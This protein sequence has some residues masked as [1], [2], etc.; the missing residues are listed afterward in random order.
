L[1]SP[2]A[3]FRVSAIAETIA[4]PARPGQPPLA[5]PPSIIGQTKASSRRLTAAIHPNIAP[6]HRLNCREIVR[7]SVQHANVR[8]VTP[9]IRRVFSPGIG[10]GLVCH[11]A[12]FSASRI[13]LE[14]KFETYLS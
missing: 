9:A 14:P 3:S 13:D 12:H 5:R 2:T 6:I 7:E 8:T 1:S 4:G 11:A 10:I